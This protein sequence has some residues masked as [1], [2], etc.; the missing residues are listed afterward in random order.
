MDE[1]ETAA[2]Q[3]AIDEMNTTYIFISDLFNQTLRVIYLNN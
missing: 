2:P 1:Q 3:S